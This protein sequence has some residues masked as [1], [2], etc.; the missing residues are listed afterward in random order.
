MPPGGRNPPVEWTL[1]DL[2]K[3]F[4]Q[5]TD[6]ASANPGKMREMKAL[7]EREA[8]ANDVYPLEH[9]F[10]RARGM[11]MLAA[12][13]M[14]RGPKTFEF[15]GKDVSLPTN[16]PPILMARSY[17][18]E[19]TLELDSTD[20]SGVVLALGSHFGGFSVYLDEGRPAFTWAKSTLPDEI[21]TVI[22]GSKLADRNTVLTMR[23]ETGRP[24]GPADV[25]LSAGE[26]EYA[27]ATVPQNLL[28]PAGGGETLDIGRDLG[29][30]VTD[31]K[32]PHGRIQGDIPHVV[33]TFD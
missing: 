2:S 19:A 17:T 32:T 21:V 6:L 3:D 14:S 26:R 25:I 28:M 23:F 12:G 10:A 13:G 31:Y 24:G 27:R 4:S 11:A 29:V 30:T 1:Y 20:A 16:T 18:V 33:V 22:S 9:L 15:W 8:K 5:S 7:W